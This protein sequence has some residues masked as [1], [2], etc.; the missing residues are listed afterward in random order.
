[1]A[2]P[3]HE[4]KYE[5]HTAEALILSKRLQ[6][7]AKRDRH[8]GA[9]GVYTVS[10]LYCDNLY[11]KAYHEKMDGLAY[12]EKFRIR[13]Y[14]QDTSCIKLERKSKVKGFCVKD[15][16]QITKEQCEALLAGDATW[17]RDSGNPLLETFYSKYVTQQLRPKSIIVYEREP[18]VYP[19]GNI[20]ITLDGRIR[21][22]PHVKDF[23]HPERVE[24]DA[25]A[26]GVTVLEV[27]YDEWLPEVVG[28]ALG[29]G[30]RSAASFSKYTTGRMNW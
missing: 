9:A 13:Y 1:M 25:T 10:S 8:A 3:R 22:S 29:I 24:Q 27:K 16:A 7:L 23:F 20:R 2:K 18:F 12:R 17:A 15:A 21:S 6:T 4:L 11:D 30:I 26:I 19:F 28:D 5:I 14:N